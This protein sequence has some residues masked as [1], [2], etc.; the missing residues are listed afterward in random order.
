M[1]HYKTSNGER[2]SKAKIDQM[3]RLA[4]SR[5]LEMQE[6]VYGYNFCED[7]K[8]N[9]TGT[10]LD[11]SHEISVDECQKSGRSEL[12]WDIDNIRIRCRECHQ[13]HDKNYI[14][15]VS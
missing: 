12:A 8:R 2:V 3:V 6:I 14:S 13:K 10:R 7:C 5:R 4:K 1:N 9:A 11:C 15:K